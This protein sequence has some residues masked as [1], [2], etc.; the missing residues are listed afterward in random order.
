MQPDEKVCYVTGSQ[1]QLDKH[2]VFPGTRRR[3][4]EKWGCWCWLR[5]DVHM[6]LHS[7]DAELEKRLK[8]ECQMAFEE[9]Y[10]HEKFMQVFGKSYL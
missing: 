8:R 4:A 9:K 10:G 2:H 6:D 3:A 5:H 7:R 1:Y